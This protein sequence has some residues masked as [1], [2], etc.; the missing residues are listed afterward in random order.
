MSIRICHP[1]GNPNSY[2]AAISLLQSGTLSRFHTLLY[3]PFGLRKRVHP[4]LPRRYV[5]THPAPEVLRLAAAHLPLGHWNGR[6]Q[7]FVDWASRSFDRWT[8]KA[9]TAR[10]RAV[11]CYE[12]SAQLTFERAFQVG[13]SRIYELPIMYYREMHD[14]LE[15]ETRQEPELAQFLQVLQEPAWKLE[16]KDRELHSAD[17]IVVAAANQSN[18]IYVQQQL[19]S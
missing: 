2:N 6:R 18:A 15:R 17:V 16:R 13:A 19:L 9:V 14:I 10:D 5:A 4:E 11:Y 12:D 3:E 7:H 1:F 8:A